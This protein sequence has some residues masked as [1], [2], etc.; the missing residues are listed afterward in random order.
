M[1]RPLARSVGPCAWWASTACSMPVSRPR[2]SIIGAPLYPCSTN[3]ATAGSSRMA[4]QDQRVARHHLSD[5][6]ATLGGLR[7]VVQTRGHNGDPIGDCN[8]QRG[9]PALQRQR[10]R[11]LCQQD[12]RPAMTLPEM[13]TA[14]RR[15][16]ADQGQGPCTRPHG[17][18]VPGPSAPPRTD[19]A[20]DAGGRRTTGTV[21]D[22]PMRRLPGGQAAPRHRGALPVGATPDDEWVGHAPRRRT[23]VQT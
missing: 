16:D 11:S 14:G 23:A 8:L 5:K 20:I 3:N 15:S 12:N 10:P 18:H 13:H 17:P 19:H 6:H 21:M 9:A 7:S 4:R 1:V 22:H 2:S